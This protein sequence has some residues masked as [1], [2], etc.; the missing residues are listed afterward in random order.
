M[1]RL[2]VRSM[3]MDDEGMMGWLLRLS[4][5]NGYPAPAMI[6]R[7]AGR[8]GTGK[9]SREAIVGR[10]AALVDAS[11]GAIDWIVPPSIGSRHRHAHVPGMKLP[12]LMLD[13][14]NPKVCPRCLADRAILPASW[15]LRLWTCCPIH[16]IRMVSHCPACA[17]P[18]TWKRRGVDACGDPD[19]DGRPSL[20]RCEPAAGPEVE[21][22][23]LIA[24]ALAPGAG[25]PRVRF[26]AVFA[27]LDPAEKLTMI[28]RLELKRGV[29]VR[30][31]IAPHRLGGRASGTVALLT[32]WPEG[33]HRHVLSL[34]PCGDSR[35]LFSAYPELRLLLSIT[36]NDALAMPERVR[37]VFLTEAL[38]ALE[39][40][41]RGPFRV[42]RAR[43]DD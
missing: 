6:L 4:E 9:L 37:A 3:P 29:A 1:T 27:S 11:P 23:R 17:K 36:G 21:L 40:G 28:A 35:G 19:C 43:R 7:L 8:A 10:L 13:A 18:L 30:D 31:A 22:V 24:E 33:F 16:S 15:D 12:G 34:Q 42:A 2:V 32:D 39:V 41:G 5:A 20:S 26:P 25:E 14:M 38:R